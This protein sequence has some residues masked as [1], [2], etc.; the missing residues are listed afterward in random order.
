MCRFCRL[1][2]TTGR[3]IGE[4]PQKRAPAS[5]SSSPSTVQ[6]RS[7]V[8]DGVKLG[9]GMFIVLPL[10]ILGGIILLLLFLAAL[11]GS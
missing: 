8:A 3:P 6:A 10:L 4:E 11:A 5:P 9:C 1:D 7:G 2:L